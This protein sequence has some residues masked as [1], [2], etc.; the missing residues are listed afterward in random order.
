MTMKES[1]NGLISLK[2]FVKRLQCHLQFMNSRTLDIVKCH[3]F[4]TEKTVPGDVKEGHFAILAAAKNHEKAEKPIRFVV[5]LCVLKHP[6]FLKLLEMA[7]EEF[8]FQ[9]KGALV[10]PCPPEELLRILQDRFW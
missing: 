2:L 7:E 9:Q 6:A 10:V 1:R 4:G 5:K 8:G 3:E